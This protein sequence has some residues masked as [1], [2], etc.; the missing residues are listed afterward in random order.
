MPSTTQ[1]GMWMDETLETT[2]DVVE[3]GSHSLRR[4]KRSWSIPMSSLSNHSNGKTRS[5][6]MGPRGVRI[7][8][9]DSAV[10]T[11]TLAMQECGLSIRLQ[12]LKMKVTE[13]T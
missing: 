5:R 9:E 7:K 1:K 11:W 10:I 4:A 6:K 12:Q 3:R 8:V 2:M 13:L